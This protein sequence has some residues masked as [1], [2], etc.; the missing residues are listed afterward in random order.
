MTAIYSILLILFLY[1]FIFVSFFIGKKWLEKTEKASIG[2]FILYGL[3]F[4]VWIMLA[5]TIG[6]WFAVKIW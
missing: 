5:V 2:G 1:V 6:C 3:I 4:V